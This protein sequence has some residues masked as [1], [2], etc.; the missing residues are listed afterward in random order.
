M[1][2]L[3]AVY[4]KLTNAE[5][6]YVTETIAGKYQAQN[7]AAILNNWAT[8]VEATETAMNSQGSAAKENEK[9]LQSI[10]GHLNQLKAAW[11]ELSRSTFSK[12]LI[13][14]VIDLGTAILKLANNDFV[15]L[16]AKIGIVVGILNILSG[17][18]IVKTIAAFMSLAA[19]ERHCCYINSSVPNDSRSVE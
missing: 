12:E 16:A 10:T 11:E 8:A 9:V 1:E 19:S 17:S 13:T 18:V 2:S 4:P 3:A 14:T 15:Q 7:A 6:A 5:K